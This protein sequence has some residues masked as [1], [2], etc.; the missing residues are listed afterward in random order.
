M[1]QTDAAWA[2]GFID[3]EG[4]IGITREYNPKYQKTY[5]KVTLM[6][7][8]VHLLPIE[9]LQLMF[10]GKVSHRDNKHQGFWTWRVSG[11]NAYSA[12]RYILPYLVAKKRQAEL[13][14]QFGE[15]NPAR[16][17]WGQ[18]MPITAEVESHRRELWVAI[19]ELN[20]GRALRAERLSEKAPL[21][22]WEDDAI[23]RP[24]GNKNRESAAEMTAPL[25]H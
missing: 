22:V 16:N 3:G 8:Q 6:V 21:W 5:Y 18:T 20:G 4:Y 24:R 12:I 2:A 13:L 23:V 10:G 9:K 15:I 11:E 7:G 25:V 17:Q 14:L 1:T 19:C